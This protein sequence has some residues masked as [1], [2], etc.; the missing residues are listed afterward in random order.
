VFP[1]TQDQLNHVHAE[2]SEILADQ[3]DRD[4]T[5]WSGLNG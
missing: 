3:Y 2:A 4:F 5:D 1:L